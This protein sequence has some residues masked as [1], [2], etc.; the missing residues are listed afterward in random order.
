MKISGHEGERGPL[1]ARRPFAARFA[2]V[3]LIL[4]LAACGPTLAVEN[5]GRA[6]IR[7]VAASKAVVVGQ[8][9]IRSAAGISIFPTRSV[10]SYES[11]PEGVWVHLVQLTD[12][13]TTFRAF[14][15]VNAN[16]RFAWAIGP[17]AYVINRISGT[18]KIMGSRPHFDPI[19]RICPRIAFRVERSTG[20]V[21]LGK[22]TIDLPPSDQVEGQ[23]ESNFCE[24]SDSYVGATQTEGE[25]T[26]LVLKPLTKVVIA[27]ELPLL[28]DTAVTDIDPSDVAEAKE[29]LRRHGLTISGLGAADGQ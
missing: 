1:E 29:V 26:R 8:I 5:I 12:D 19:W 15:D 14:P 11:P 24:E 4:M 20:I 7:K 13:N 21:N 16:G 25:I 2:A 28:P 17:G 6:E 9:H 22:I 3:A 10:W 23:D 18:S 27:P